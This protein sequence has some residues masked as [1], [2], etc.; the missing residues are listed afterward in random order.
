ME[1]LIK[2]CEKIVPG[3]AV[4]FC[5]PFAG[6]G[7]AA[8]NGWVKYFQNSVTVC[9]VQLPGREEKIGEIPYSDMDTLVDDLVQEIKQYDRNKIILFGHSMGAKMAY[10]VAKK[11]AEADFEIE[12]LI[13]SGSRV[14]H[15][16]E[17]NPIHDL[18]DEEF[19]NE[20]S[21]FDGT[22]KAIFEN[23]ELLNF[24]MPMLR[25]DFIMD[26]TYHTSE[27]VKLS[28]PIEALGGISDKE[29]DEETMVKWGEYAESIF[30]LS[31]F[32][33]GHFFI[34]EK[35]DEVLNKVSEIIREIEGL[36]RI[37]KII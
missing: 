26:E 1:K 10:G 15:I 33:G 2:N 28:C 25:A 6:G 16:M 24:F 20:I 23:K 14:P 19:A 12:V 27:I 37:S 18:P 22:P 34:R 35:E 3:K 32:E 36:N 13:V 11:L 5:F 29:A 8:F 21:R 4:M 31:M 17:P 30:N 7:A 9:P